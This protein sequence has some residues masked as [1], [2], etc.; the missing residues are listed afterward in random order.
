MYV[1]LMRARRWPEARRLLLGHLLFAA[2]FA[3][4]LVPQ[5][6]AYQILNGRPLPS[7]R[8]AAS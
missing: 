2:I 5:L 7:Q 4:T 3:A 1:N 8:S 6:V